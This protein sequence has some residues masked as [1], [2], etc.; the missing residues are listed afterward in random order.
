MMDIEHAIVPRVRSISLRSIGVFQELDVVLSPEKNFIRGENGI[1]KSTLLWSAA[2]AGNPLWKPMHHRCADAYS[3]GAIA[4]EFLPAGPAPR[5]RFMLPAWAKT[6]GVS[7]S[8]SALLQL[9]YWLSATPPDHALLFDDDI[10]ASL[11]FQKRDSALAMI[12]GAECQILA[13]VP[14]NLTREELPLKG[15][16]GLMLRVVQ[17]DGGGATL[18]TEPFGPERTK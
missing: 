12:A 16:T 7:M 17:A 11:D 10:L 6:N 5:S 2:H 9:E 4:V 8:D 18:E 14:Q 1:G 13:V 15:I 3:K